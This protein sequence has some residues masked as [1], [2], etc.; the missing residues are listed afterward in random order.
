MYSDLP[1]PAKGTE[2]TIRKVLNG[3][4]VEFPQEKTQMIDI[5]SKGADIL[6][7]FRKDDLGIDEPVREPE[8]KQV[9]YVEMETKVFRTLKQLLAFLESEFSEVDDQLKADNESL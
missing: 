3:Y 6:R 5:V 8:K 4:I 2:I 1:R 9:T 7:Q